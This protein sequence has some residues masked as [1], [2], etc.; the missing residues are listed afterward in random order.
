MR[1]AAHRHD[2]AWLGELGF[3]GQGSYTGWLND[4]ETIYYGSE[5]TGYA[6]LYTVSAAGGAPKALTS[7]QWEV[8]DVELSPDKKTF[9]LATNE[10]DWGQAHFWTMA[11]AGGARTRV[12]SAEGRQDVTVS[13]D[14]RTLAVLASTSNHPAELFFQEARPGGAVRQITESTTPEWRSYS[15]SNPDIPPPPPS[16]PSPPPRP[17]YPPA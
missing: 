10:G 6:H 2:D 17:L 7:G 3:L 14:G 5:E 13:P 15:W 11:V 8:Q 16:P 12:T 4:G 9:W 1:T